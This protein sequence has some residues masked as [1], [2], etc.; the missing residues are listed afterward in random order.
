MT[1]LVAGARP[2]GGGGVDVP[3]APGT[4]VAGRYRILGVAGRGGMGFVYRALRLTT[5]TPVALKVM[6]KSMLREPG[7]AARFMNEGRLAARISHP[8]VVEIEDIGQL[9]DGRPFLAMPLLEGQTTFELL[10]TRGVFTVD[11]VVLIL[12]DLASALDAVH[13]AGI[14]HR[15][16]KPE[17]VFLHRFDGGGVRPVLIDFGLATTKTSQRWTLEG[18]VVGTPEYLAPEACDGAAPTRTVDHYGLAVAVYEWLTDTVPFTGSPAQVLLRKVSQK[19]PPLS[20]CGMA[21]GPEIEAVV[22]RALSRRPSERFDTATEFATAFE[23]AVRALPR[24]EGAPTA[25]EGADISGTY[26]KRQRIVTGALDGVFDAAALD[27]AVAELQV[28]GPSPT[29]PERLDPTEPVAVAEERLEQSS[30]QVVEEKPRPVTAEVEK[31]SPPR[32]ARRVAILAAAGTLVM[33]ALAFTGTGPSVAAERRAPPTVAAPAG[34]DF[35]LDEA[36]ETEPTPV[37]TSARPVTER[38]K[39]P[40]P[41]PEVVA[42]SAEPPAAEAMTETGPGARHRIEAGSRALLGGD[43]HSARRAFARATREAPTDTAAW[44]GLGLAHERLGDV[45]AA[46]RAYRRAL[47]HASA[48]EAAPLRGR[49]ERL[50]D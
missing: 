14:V 4:E 15:D 39:R 49:L 48:A 43:F 10:E 50:A 26:A 38:T 12:R 40:A 1:G 22:A 17:N 45:A 47:R 33:G 35:V 29:R 27:Q 3:M 18:S 13:G 41:R 36:L 25:P 37:L 20:A 11:E 6:R 8:N 32:T 44:R 31:L 2:W 28:P 34:P 5:A 7:G 19:A 30:E 24:P 23:A 16:L 42:E 21:F 9:D 46:R